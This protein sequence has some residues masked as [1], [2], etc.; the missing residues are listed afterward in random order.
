MVGDLLRSRVYWADTRPVIGAA[1]SVTLA[2]AQ[3]GDEIA[4]AC[5]FRDV[6]PAL[7]RYLKVMT[8]D[9]EDVAGETWVQVVKSL[10][11]FRGSEEAFRAWLFTIARH[12]A[13]DAS[14]SKARRPDVP[15][16][17]SEAGPQP[18]APDAADL[19]LESISTRSVLNLIMNLPREHAEI[20]M[21]RVVAGLEAADVARIV[22]KTPGAV[23]VT[24]HRAL[25]RLSEL[26]EL[27]GVTH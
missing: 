14:R 1:F 16:I 23:R 22:G 9:A 24:A 13:V 19:A 18:M 8:P 27:A 21:L 4:F 3:G 10:P 7:L 12:R 6:Q 15:L 11:G 17:E 5:L 20:I 26:A 2:S 25:R